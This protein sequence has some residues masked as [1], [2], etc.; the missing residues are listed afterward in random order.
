MEKHR[1]KRRF[2]AASPALG[3]PL[4]VAGAPHS[5]LDANGLTNI[6]PDSRVP[7]DDLPVL[8]ITPGAEFT[9]QELDKAI[10]FAYPMLIKFPCIISG[11]SPQPKPSH[12]VRWGAYHPGIGVNASGEPH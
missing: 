1:N 5:H 12:V 7:W 11:S 4:K 3:N 10:P 6:K 2:S 8:R 9:I